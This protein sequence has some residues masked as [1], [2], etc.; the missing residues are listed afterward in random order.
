ME[1][2]RPARLLSLD[3]F[4][5]LTIAGMLVV[6]S[7]GNNAAYAPLEHAQWHGCTPTDL[8]FPFFLFIVGAAAAF[9]LARRK[10]AGEVPWP[11]ML[12]RA[13]ALF[14]L[15]LFLCAIP[16]WHPETIRILGVLQRIALCYLAVSWIYLK[17]GPR[18]QAALA[19]A[20]LAGYAAALAWA[21]LTPEASLPCRLDRLLLGR[22]AYHQGLFDPEGVLSTLPAIATTL[23]GL[24]A[25]QWLRSAR[26]AMT[27]VWGLALA[28]AAAAAAGAVWSLWL[29]LNKSLWTSS[30]VLY[31][32][33]LA[34][35]TLAACYW[36]LDVRGWRAWAGPL[37]V[38]GVNAI[39]AYVLPILGLK[40]LV[41]TRVGG[42]QLR[43]RICDLMFGTWLSPMNASLAFALSYLALWTGVFWLFRRKGWVWKV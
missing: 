23:L 30:Y 19:G 31:T 20:L 32:G 2:E 29:P 39:A 35:M 22:H 26:L 37:E 27:K 34:A 7:P 38:L 18:G 24:L 13:A 1:A 6:N 17:T 5:G 9:A 25:G 16:D 8:V 11:Q 14:G 4:R 28:G 21:P 15:G 41:L 42:E 36:V 43:I 12:R 3:A 40:F 10:E 33:G